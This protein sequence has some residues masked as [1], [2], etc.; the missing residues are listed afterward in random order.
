L[1]KLC[2]LCAF[3]KTTRSKNLADFAVNSFLPQRITKY[4][5][6]FC[7]VSQSWTTQRILLFNI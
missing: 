7:K 3:Y 5:A 6:K 4:F 2:E 1:I